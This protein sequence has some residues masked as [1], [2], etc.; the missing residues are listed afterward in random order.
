[1]TRFYIE[2]YQ[3]NGRQILGNLDGQTA[4]DCQDI[5]RT[6]HYRALKT[7]LGR[8]KWPRVAYWIV[9]RG[10]YPQETIHNVHSPHY[11]RTW[12]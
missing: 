8:P 11:R 4:R 2:A 3:A 9:V 6:Q 12:S 7:G 5:T 10:D 1:M